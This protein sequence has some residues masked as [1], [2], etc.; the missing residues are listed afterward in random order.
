MKEKHVLGYWQSS[1]YG[2]PLS[3][4]YLRLWYSLSIDKTGTADD[5]VEKGSDYEHG[6]N[7]AKDMAV[8][9]YYYACAALAKHPVGLNN[10]ACCLMNGS[11]S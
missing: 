11:G 7:V 4:K 8:A 5:W 6:R 2:C 9:S 10:L 3:D 1:A